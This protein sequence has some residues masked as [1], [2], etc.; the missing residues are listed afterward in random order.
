MAPALCMTL[1]VK[2]G[3]FRTGCTGIGR[4]PAGRVAAA[5]VFPGLEFPGI[6]HSALERCSPGHAGRAGPFPLG[7]VYRSIRRLSF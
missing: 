6:G 7:K 2:T 4:A 3:I 1:L 5:P